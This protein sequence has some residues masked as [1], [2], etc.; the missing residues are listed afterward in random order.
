MSVV[1]CRLIIF[2]IVMLND[3]GIQYAFI[4]RCISKDLNFSSL[5]LGAF[6]GV[7]H[8]KLSHK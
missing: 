7:S 3:H 6:D 4:F 5:I 1:L 8:S 2:C